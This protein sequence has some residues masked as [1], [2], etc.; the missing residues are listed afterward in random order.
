[1]LRCIPWQ[2][3]PW[4]RDSSAFT[5]APETRLSSDEWLDDHQQGLVPGGSEPRQE[6]F[7]QFKVMPQKPSLLDMMRNDME[8]NETA[9]P[10]ARTCAHSY[11]R[12]RLQLY[13]G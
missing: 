9:P 10:V 5:P 6:Y 1:M 8:E 12:I 3:W 7:P 4:S 2:E 11:Y 13:H